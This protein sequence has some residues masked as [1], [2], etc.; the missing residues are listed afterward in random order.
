M[1]HLAGTWSPWGGNLVGGGSKL[2][3]HLKW[4]LPFCQKL[5]ITGG[6]HEKDLLTRDKGLLL[7]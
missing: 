7:C 3:L 5:A 4:S 2:F 1:Q 6:Q